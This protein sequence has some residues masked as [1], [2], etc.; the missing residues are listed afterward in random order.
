MADDKNDPLQVISDLEAI[1]EPAADGPWYAVN[2]DEK[3]GSEEWDRAANDESGALSETRHDLWECWTV[4]RKPSAAGWDTDGGIPGYGVGSAEARLMAA[5]R[6]AL[7]A[8]LEA[9][10]RAIALIETERMGLEEWK[11]HVSGILE[12]LIAER[13]ARSAGVDDS[14]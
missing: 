1:C 8:A 4:S 13:A 5:S 3:T 10:R 12:P 2:G 6:T 14:L 9:L 7:P 11:R